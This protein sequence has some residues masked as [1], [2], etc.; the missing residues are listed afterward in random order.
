MANILPSYETPSNIDAVRKNVQSFAQFPALLQRTML[1]HLSHITKNNV[2][3]VDST[4]PVAF[5]IE[6]AAV[7]TSEFITTDM[8][9]NRKQYPFASQTEDD[10]YLHMC[11]EDYIGRF[12]LP[13]RARLIIIMEAAEV[14]DKMVYDS[15]LDIRKLTIP[16]NTRFTVGG[17][18]FTLEYPINIQQFRHGGIQVLYDGE[19]PSPLQTLN[20]NI[21]NWEL[22]DN[23]DSKWITF[24]VEVLQTYMQSELINISPASPTRRDILFND[25]FFH[26]RV[27]YRNVGDI[28]KEMDT[29]HTPELYDIAR[30]MAVLKVTEGNLNV[31]IPQIYTNQQ[32]LNGEIRVDLYTTKGDLN[33]SL[34]GYAPTDYEAEFITVDKERDETIFVAPVRALQSWRNFSNDRTT[35]G[36]A[37]LSF[38]ELRERVIRNATGP[39]NIPIS[40]V[41][42]TKV[43]EDE[44]F[45]TV[46]NTDVVTNRAYLASRAL[47]I[48]SNAKL[49]TAASA[50]IETLIT[51]INGLKVSD[52]VIDN[53]SSIT[54]TPDVIYEM[55][56]GKLNVVP[57]YRIRELLNMTPE[58]R[59]LA[60]NKKNY[61]YTPFHYVMDMNDNEFDFRAYYLNS[62]IVENKTFIASNPT[63]NLEVSVDN[64]YVNKTKLGYELYIQTKS[65]DT[66]KEISNDEVF[67]QLSFKPKGERDLA[68]L[69][70]EFVSMTPERERIYKFKLDSNFNL[71]VNNDLILT[72][73]KMYDNEPR[74]IPVGLEQDFNII[75]S[76][77]TT[78]GSVYTRSQ[79]DDKLALWMLPDEPKAIINE[80]IRLRFGHALNSL[81]KQSRTI[82]STEDYE[83]YPDDIP[84]TYE[85]N[86]YENIRV[87]NGKVVY[88]VVHEKGDPVLD[89]KGNPVM[90]H[91][92]GDVILGVNG[93]PIVKNMRDLARQ[94]DIMLIEAVY[95]FATDTIAAAYRQEIIDTFLD[96]M[97]DG[98]DP[99][100]AR[101][102]EQTKIYFYP[103]ATLGQVN[104]MYNNGV[105]TKIDAAQSLV[106]DLVVN[107]NVYSNID[108][109]KSIT[110]TT[111]QVINE[112]LSS[113]TI[114][115]SGI[116]ASLTNYYGND[117]LGVKMI[118]LGGDKDSEITAMT[119]LD[120]A[121]RCCLKKRLTTQ[122]DNTIIVEED[123]TVN[124]ILMDTQETIW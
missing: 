102:L 31:F 57:S 108:L 124:F 24:E 66:F 68:Y 28:W 91:R 120:E 88:D 60:I 33:V 105:R 121:K 39:K 100:N 81:W 41:Q 95:Y 106:I 2:Q 85:K 87:E 72:N 98:L 70:G 101:T 116:Y 19:I 103:R 76:T 73:F 83:R 10:L 48:P 67:V 8:N 35:G 16:R 112:L 99:L 118:G 84:M 53:G 17:M 43:L 12:A 65:S 26:A 44:G 56:N 97:I 69:N 86:V 45:T 34:D 46:L 13:S 110:V 113:D 92:K 6:A 32:I 123:I 49:I 18:S 90:K 36:R 111:I 51:S 47:P 61:Y 30:P 63:T 59:S 20:S 104:I 93:K 21:I 42:I 50:S 94:M 119:V 1:E 96:W 107:R 62:P 37:P 77:N 58:Q 82:T 122:T 4:N 14:L 74:K 54:L 38:T 23:F 115:D 109:R 89:S 5:T 52:E 64:Y 11:D 79:I 7:L 80:N 27:Y 22:L 75:F 25:H 117:V 40:N 71:N 15:N 78:L 114:S 9:L 55:E 3:I 29:T